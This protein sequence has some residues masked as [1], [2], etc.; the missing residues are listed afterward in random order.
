MANAEDLVCHPLSLEK[1]ESANT[2]RDIISIKSHFTNAIYCQYYGCSR[3]PPNEFRSATCGECGAVVSRANTHG[4]YGITNIEFVELSNCQ[5]C[6]DGVCDNEM[7]I[8][9]RRILEL[10]PKIRRAVQRIH[11]IVCFD[12]FCEIE[13]CE[14]YKNKLRELVDI[15]N[16]RS[17]YIW[18]DALID[19]LNL[20]KRR[21]EAIKNR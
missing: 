18:Q 4:I 19:Q 16:H 12:A 15:S 13:Q 14:F 1:L 7:H 3:K 21:L 8:R 2:Q 6:K 17:D 10:S 9:I 20:Q 5:N 11:S